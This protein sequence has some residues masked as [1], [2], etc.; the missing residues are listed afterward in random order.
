MTKYIYGSYLSEDEAIDAASVLEL[1]GL[2]AKNITILT[3]HSKVEDLAKL[4]DVNIQTANGKAEHNEPILDQ[5]RRRFG[6]DEPEETDLYTR[7]I[8][9]LGIKPEIARKCVDDVQMGRVLMIVDDEMRMGHERLTTGLD[10]SI[11][12]EN[13]RR[14]Y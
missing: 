1:K 7:L 9:D 5:I 6:K 10:Q 11:V 8:D 14:A 12:A 13:E 4:T 2:K 3:N